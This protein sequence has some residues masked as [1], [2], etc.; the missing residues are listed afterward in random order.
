MTIRSN[1]LF[2]GDNLDVLRKYIPEESVDLIYLDLPFNSKTDYNILFKESTGEESTAQIQAFT[3]FW[4]WDAVAN[5]AYYYLV[6]EAPNTDT[7]DL[8]EAIFKF[9]GRNDMMAYLVMMGERLLELHR[10]LKSTD[11][12]FLHCDTT[13]SHYLKLLLD[14]I[15]EPRNFRNEIIWK[16]F[17]FHAD[18]KRFGRVSDR[19]LFYSKTDEYK[20][21]R[22]RAPF[23][24]DYIESHFTYKDENGQRYTTSDLNPPGGRGPIYEFHGIKRPWRFEEKKIL[25]LEKKGLIYTKSK[26]PRLIRYLDELEARGGAAVHE[27]WDD[28]SLNS[29]ANER[30]GFQTQKPSPLLERVIKAGSDRGD[31]VLDPFCGCGTAIAAAEKLGRRWIG[32]DVT[33]LAINLVKKRVKDSFPDVNFIVEGEPKDLGAAKELAKN[34]YQFQW[35]ALS[36]ID[37]KPVGSTLAKPEAGR[38]G[39]DEGVDGWIRLIDGLEGPVKKV[40]VQVKSG[41]VSVKDIREL[42]D[43]VMRQKGVI[44]VFITLEEPTSEM[45]KEVKTTDPYVSTKWNREYPAIQILTVAE[46]LHGKK[47]ELPPAISPLQEAPRIEK[48]RSRFVQE[49][50][51]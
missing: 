9:L 35:W 30:L 22:V 5:R 45:V 48:I 2:Y 1:T 31:W 36:L 14:S 29:M 23:K 25:E 27:I 39:A 20:F 37:A 44:G 33:Y 19:L 7:A 11:S 8:I 13:A 51:A 15:F 38:K 50:L 47:P 28:I 6:T 26:V 18:A 10:V 12:L 4:H 41:H 24:K 42:R 43:V 21:R 46:L 34:P 16:R 49:K 3:D 17:N 40:V 32:I